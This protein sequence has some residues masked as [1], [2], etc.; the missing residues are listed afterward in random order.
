M[1]M[2]GGEI[3]DR[4]RGWTVIQRVVPKVGFEPTRAFM[5]NGF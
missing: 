1:S 5:P 4:S 2:A 3:P